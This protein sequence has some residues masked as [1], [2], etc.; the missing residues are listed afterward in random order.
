MARDEE[1]SHTS[2]SLRRARMRD[3]LVA[4]REEGEPAW[5]G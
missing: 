5:E 2:A 3:S 4:E 1:R